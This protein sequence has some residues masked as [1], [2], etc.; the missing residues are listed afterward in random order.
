MVLF[1][2]GLIRLQPNT[3]KVLSHFTHCPLTELIAYSI[4]G[5]ALVLCIDNHICDQ[6]PVDLYI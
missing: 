2:G 3:V 1:S 5:I 6:G 4:T